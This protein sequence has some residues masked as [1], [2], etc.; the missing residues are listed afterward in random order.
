MEQAVGKTAD[1]D[2]GSGW[3]RH[4]GVATLVPVRTK[5]FKITRFYATFSS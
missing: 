5:N 2:R 1:I 4:S 3:S